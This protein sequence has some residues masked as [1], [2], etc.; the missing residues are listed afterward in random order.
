[1]F[2]IDDIL[3]KHLE[4]HRNLLGEE[5]GIPSSQSTS[6]GVSALLR[7]GYTVEEKNGGKLIAHENARFVGGKKSVIDGEGS[8]VIACDGAMLHGA[9]FDVRGPNS[10]ILIGPKARLRQVHLIADGPGAVIIIG[11]ET[12][13]ESGSA[14]AYPG[15]TISIGYDCMFSSGIILRTSDGH[16]IFDL[17][18]RKQ[19]NAPA[20]IAIGNHVW[21]GN[22]AR[23]NKGVTIHGGSIIGQQSIV[24]GKVYGRSIYAG[25]PAK[26]IKENIAWSRSHAFADIPLDFQSRS[27]NE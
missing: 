4:A 27:I 19:I 10:V 1:M 12:S 8:C 2:D 21:M 3:S 7:H 9:S 16:G 24:S 23:V 14:L 20:N 22:G 26:K 13:W 15:T 18:T 5:I 25:I 6:K 11:G 17:A